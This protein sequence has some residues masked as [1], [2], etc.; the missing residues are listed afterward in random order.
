MKRRFQRGDV[1][2][3]RSGGPQMTV[4]EEKKG[5]VICDW[6]EGDTTR[7][8]SFYVEQLTPVDRAPDDLEIARRVAALLQ[9]T[10]AKAGSPPPN[11]LNEGAGETPREEAAKE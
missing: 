5:A 1:V 7:R 11:S 3:L 10:L 6:S 2:R 8:D 9:E 4:R